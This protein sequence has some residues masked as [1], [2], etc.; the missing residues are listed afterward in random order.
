MADNYSV[1]VYDI[2]TVPSQIQNPS[3][4]LRRM[5]VRINLSCWLVK[6]G[7][8]PFQVIEDLN[9]GIGVRWFVTPVFAGDVDSMLEFVRDNLQIE[10]REHCERVTA[11]LEAGPTTKQGRNPSTDPLDVTRWERNIRLAQTRVT[12]LIEDSEVACSEFGLDVNFRK[13]TGWLSRL[14]QRIVERT[15]AVQNAA[16]TLPTNDPIRAA[17]LAQEVPDEI[18]ADYVQDNGGETEGEILAE[19]TRSARDGSDRTG[20]SSHWDYR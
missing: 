10:L 13:A 12:K 4:N 5:C 11:L 7:R 8:I 16:Y 14:T 19:V 6:N 2:P 15:E 3:V 17:A 20:T 9:R 18:L 1:L